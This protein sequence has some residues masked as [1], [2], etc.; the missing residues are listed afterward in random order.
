MYAR[1]FFEQKILGLANGTSIL[2]NRILCCFAV[3]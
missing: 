1:D 2:A 3:E